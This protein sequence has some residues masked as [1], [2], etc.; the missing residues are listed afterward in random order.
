MSNHTKGTWKC[1]GQMIVSED[2]EERLVEIANLT[3]QRRRGHSG[4][5]TADEYRANGFLIA[6]APELLEA[7][8]I[9]VEFILGMHSNN[10]DGTPY[11]KNIFAYKKLIKAIKRAEG[12]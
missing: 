9:S 10:L 5:E 1:L 12:K 8:K 6:T 3:S 11:Y 7:C 4:P 2:D